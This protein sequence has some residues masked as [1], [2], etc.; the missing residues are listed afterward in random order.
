[1]MPGRSGSTEGGTHEVG[2][3][4]RKTRRYRK[5]GT[6]MRR[7][8]WGV[9]GVGVGPAIHRRGSAVAVR[10]WSSDGGPSFGA[11]GTR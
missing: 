11:A 9:T 5:H 8:A 3:P 6:E 7:Q 4:W 2:G 10:A 1:M